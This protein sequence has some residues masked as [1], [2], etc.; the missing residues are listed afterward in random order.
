MGQAKKGRS[1][2][3]IPRWKHWLSYIN[4]LPIDKS[5]GDNGQALEVVLK[6]GRLMLT[7]DHAIYSYDDYY[8][9]FLEAFMMVKKPWDQITSVLVLGMGLG[10]IPYMLEHKF[11]CYPRFTLIEKDESVIDLASRY[12]LS[13]LESDCE[14]ISADA[15][16]F[17][18]GNNDRFDMICM[19]VFVDDKIPEHMLGEDYCEMLKSRLSDNGLLLYNCLYQYDEDKKIVDAF[20]NDIF[21]RVFDNYGFIDVEGNRIFFSDKSHMRDTL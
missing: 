17:I 20:E 7:S 15:Y 4:E 18:A 6:K 5:I 12:S 21:S 16:S 10:S 2:K 1:I 3:S 13:R 14:I 9:N 8:V 19:D 11:Y